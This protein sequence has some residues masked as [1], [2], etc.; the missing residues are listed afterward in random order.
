MGFKKNYGGTDLTENISPIIACSLVVGETCPQRS[1]DATAIA[2]LAVYTAP[3]WHFAHMSIY[4]VTWR[5]VFQLHAVL[6]K[7]IQM[8][9]NASWA[10]ESK[11]QCRSQIL[12]LYYLNL[13]PSLEVPWWCKQ[14]QYCKTCFCHPRLFSAP[15][16]RAIPWTQM[17]PLPHSTLDA[18][19]NFFLMDPHIQG[20]F[21][22]FYPLSH[23]RWDQLWFVPLRG[24]HWG[25]EI[26]KSFISYA[27]GRA[28]AQAVSSRLPIAAVRVRAR[29]R[30][31]GICGGQS[32]TGE[33]SLRVLLFFDRLC[34]LVVKSSWLQIQR[35]WFDDLRYQIFWRVV[36]LERG[37]FSLVSIQLRSYLEEKVSGIESRE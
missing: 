13:L 2:K 18:V 11:K 32:S 36:H 28:V 21:G 19:S 31:C 25:A 14:L 20:K 37:P 4:S 8:I 5:C 34:G 1:S 17:S 26:R 22:N 30:S 24:H 23:F 3:P 15:L 29:V 27:F 7:G 10:G 35:S 12:R 6:L 33:G 16:R 9:T